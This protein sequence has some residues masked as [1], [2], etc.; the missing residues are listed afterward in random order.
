MFVVDRCHESIKHIVHIGTSSLA[1]KKV[2]MELQSSAAIILNF[3]II[4]IL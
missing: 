4:L 2:G 3:Y 1:G